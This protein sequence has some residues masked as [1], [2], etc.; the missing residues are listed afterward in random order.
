MPAKIPVRTQVLAT[1]A[2]LTLSLA[3]WAILVGADPV[4]LLAGVPVATAA[5]FLANRLVPP[6]GRLPSAWRV[7]LI[8]PGF[9]WRSIRGGVDVARRVFDPR[10]PMNPGWI[11]QESA[12][13]AGAPRVIA[14]GEISLLP[15]TLVAGSRGG[16]LLVHCLDTRMPIRQQVAEEEARFRR[17]ADDD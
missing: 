17:T 11:E 1:A 6:D 4:G 16:R 10:L 3:C 8:A 2:R 12:L 15:G 5:T 9:L 14:S 7:L 13:Q